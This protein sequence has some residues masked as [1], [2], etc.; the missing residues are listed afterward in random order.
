MDSIYTYSKDS[1]KN[2]SDLRKMIFNA[3]LESSLNYIEPKSNVSHKVKLLFSPFGLPFIP[4]EIVG[5]DVGKIVS[6]L[7]WTKD[8]TNPGGFLSISITPD[9]R[10]INK[11][12]EILNKLSK[13]YY[14]KIW[15]SLGVDL[16]DLFKP[17]TLCQLWID[18]YHIMTGTV[19]SLSRSA[20][21]TN[22]DYQTSYTIVIEELG[23]LY[24]KN[25]LSLDTVIMDGMNTNVLDSV[26]KAIEAVGKLRFVTLQQ[27]IQAYCTAFQLSILSEQGIGGSDGLPLAFRMFASGNPLGGIANLAYAQ[28]ST[29][30]ADIFKLNGGQSFWDFIKNLVPN[31]WMELYTESG[32]RTIVT[33]PIGV[34]SVLFPGINYVVARSTPYSNPLLGIV[35]PVH[36]PTLF[37]FDLTAINMLMGGDFIIITDDMIQEKSLGFDA[38]NQATV[39]RTKYTAG[40]ATIAS[41]KADRPIQ[42]AGPLNPF[43]SGGMTT[44]GAVEM[45]QVFNCL[46]LFEGGTAV[47]VALNNTKEKVST[48]GVLS[49]NALSNQLAVWFRNQSRFR[50]G[51]VKSR[52]I[53][54]ARPGM[55]CLYLPTKSGKKPENLRDIG[56]YYIDSLSHEYSLTN[57]GMSGSTT[58]NLIRG[59]PMPMTVAQSALLLFDWEV[60]PP[61]SGLF[62]GEF[63]VLNALRKASTII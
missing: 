52:L 1:F 40:G 37:P 46:Q 50:E 12:V 31:P 28:G 60:L 61:V 14:S 49:K 18:G 35:N 4:L 22:T 5:S 41:S 39:F 26:T 51:Q 15:G 17:M 63:S 29:V 11:M 16:E 57:E 10:M 30:S 45:T 47:D 25:T 33:D 19:R 48:L 8:R 58:L 2:P 38:V 6:N 27:A 20:G 59:V 32:G 3:G 7:S 56:M 21:V 62:D 24:T 43:A 55:Y 36:Y 34:P 54:Y 9:S 53:P 44:F 42:S 13:N 23:N